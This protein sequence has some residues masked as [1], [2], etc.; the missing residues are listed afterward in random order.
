M[1]IFNSSLLRACIYVFYTLVDLQRCSIFLSCKSTNNIVQNR[2]ILPKYELYEFVFSH[3]YLFMY[4]FCVRANSRNEIYYW[5]RFICN[6][7]W[8]DLEKLRSHWT[9]LNG[10]R[11]VCLRWCLVS[12]SDL[13]NLHSHPSHEQRYG[14]SPEM[15]K[16]NWNIYFLPNRISTSF[17]VQMI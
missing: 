4:I 6:A 14:F 13:A 7:R 16:N 17:F 10:L 2:L 8:S 15:K 5:C 3:W 11:P 1:A 12:S 9:H